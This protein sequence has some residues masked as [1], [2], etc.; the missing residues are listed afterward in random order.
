MAP[1]FVQC[2]T[3][4]NPSDLFESSVENNFYDKIIAIKFNPLPLNWK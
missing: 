4:F 1:L 2:N 3:E